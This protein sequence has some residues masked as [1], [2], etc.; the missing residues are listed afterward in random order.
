M[1]PSHQLD[2]RHP[3]TFV[4]TKKNA[5]GVCVCVCVRCHQGVLLAGLCGT[6]ALFV[7]CLEH[8]GCDHRDSGVDLDGLSDESGRIGW[9]RGKTQWFFAAH[10]RGAIDFLPGGRRSEDRNHVED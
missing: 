9:D 8:H 4:I 1:P 3:T 10:F 7:Q 2:F 6:W 5:C